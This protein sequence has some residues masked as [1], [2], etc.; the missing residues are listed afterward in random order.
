ML[1]QKSA[2]P[3][4]GTYSDIANL[5]YSNGK[6]LSKDNMG[7]DDVKKYNQFISDKAASD[8]VF[9]EACMPQPFQKEEWQQQSL[10]EMPTVPKAKLIL[11]LLS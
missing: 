5:I 9:Q 2:Q 4:Y 3:N 7:Y 6:Q 11:T 10:Q 1:Q 8:P